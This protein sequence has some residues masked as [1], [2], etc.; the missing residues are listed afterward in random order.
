MPRLLPLLRPWP[1]Q[2]PDRVLPVIAR[3]GA[4]FI[5]NHVLTLAPSHP[6]ALIDRP[7]VRLA[8]FISQ[9]ILR[10]TPFWLGY[11]L[12]GATLSPSVTF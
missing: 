4:K 7:Q 1:V 12:N 9:P 6:V 3:I 11:I 2:E 8:P 10:I 5:Q